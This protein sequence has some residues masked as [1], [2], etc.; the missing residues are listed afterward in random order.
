MRSFIPPIYIGACLGVALGEAKQ[1]SLKAEPV[2]RVYDW[3]G[4]MTSIFSF[5]MD[6]QLNYVN[7]EDVLGDSTRIMDRV[8]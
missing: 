7:S 4:P 8:C 6:T 1:A 3:T 5:V 2:G